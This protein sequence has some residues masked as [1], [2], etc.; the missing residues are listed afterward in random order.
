MREINDLHISGCDDGIDAVLQGV[1]YGLKQLDLPSLNTMPEELQS[2]LCRA[3]DACDAA[4][5][6]PDAE[7]A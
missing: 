3:C 4:S 1:A 5:S 6:E 7:L 2:L